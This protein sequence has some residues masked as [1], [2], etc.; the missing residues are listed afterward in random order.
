MVKLRG[1]RTL[2][3][4]ILLRTRRRFIVVGYVRPG[5]LLGFRGARSGTTGTALNGFQVKGLAAQD[6]GD[7]ERGR[8]LLA[9][10]VGCRGC[11]SLGG[12]MGAA[13]L[14]MPSD[15]TLPCLT[16]SSRGYI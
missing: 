15:E 2:P 11:F 6:G 4:S 16:S 7:D 5:Q 10:G 3:H 9:H 8:V 12:G 14:V 13:V 1:T